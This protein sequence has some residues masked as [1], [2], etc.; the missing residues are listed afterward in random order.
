MEASFELGATITGLSRGGLATSMVAPAHVNA[1]ATE[2]WTDWD[3]GQR[4]WLGPGQVVTEE[5][6]AQGQGMSRMS[7]YAQ[8][9]T[10]MQLSDLVAFLDE[11]E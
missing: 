5:E 10:V 11:V 8:V 7:D 3:A 1:Q 6:E 4:V 9:M 2:L